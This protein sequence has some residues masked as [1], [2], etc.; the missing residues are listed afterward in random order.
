MVL[1]RNWC[2]CSAHKIHSIFCYLNLCVIVWCA[3]LAHALLHCC[4]HSCMLLSC[5]TS[6]WT[7]ST[8][9]PWLFISGPSIF[10]IMVNLS[11][12]LLLWCHLFFVANSSFLCSCDVSTWGLLL[13][14]SMNVNH[15]SSQLQRGNG[16]SCEMNECAVCMTN[17]LK[18]KQ[19]QVLWLLTT[20]RNKFS[21]LQ[22]QCSSRKFSTLSLLVITCW[23]LEWY[24]QLFRLAWV[25]GLFYL[26]KSPSKCYYYCIILGCL[27]A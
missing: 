25:I 13:Y 26:E 2:C 20:K 19:E 17:I 21:V 10:P 11:S 18:E 5:T 9:M 8:A 15:P 4:I 7:F 6:P 1:R 27:L 12:S 16:Q 3:F 24:S 22:E 23:L 14:G